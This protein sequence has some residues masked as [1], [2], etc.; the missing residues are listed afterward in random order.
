MAGQVRAVRER[1]SARLA[2][3]RTR[4]GVYPGMAVQIAAV[5][6]TFSAHVANERTPILVDPG[7]LRQIP[8]RVKPFLAQLALERFLSA[9]S[10]GM[11]EQLRVG[12]EPFTAYITD[13][14]LDPD[15]DLFV[16]A[17]STQLQETLVTYGTGIRTIPGVC[18]AMSGQTRTA[19]EPLT[20]NVTHKGPV[21]AVV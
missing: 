2:R 9:V 18:P 8:V 21:S 4:S 3:E 5:L 16:L 15:V 14:H 19:D 10:P 7:M 17:D 13:K 11:V 12:H 6:E 20:A 1:L